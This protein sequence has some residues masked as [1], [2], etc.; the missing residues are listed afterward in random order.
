MNRLPKLLVITD[1]SLGEEPLLRQLEAALGAGP[2]VAV[3]HRNPGATARVYFEQGR[4]LK[5]LCDRFGA[6]LFVSARLDIA[7][8]LDAHLHLP[9]AALE[10]AQVRTR[11]P[12]GRWV[13]VAVHNEEE[14]ARAGGADLALVSPVF[15]TASKPG[16]VA[17]GAEGFARLARALPCPAYA[18]GG[19]T[20]GRLSGLA[21]VAG[22][23]AISAVLQAADPGAMSRA[24]C[25]AAQGSIGR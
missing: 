10:P 18:L 22:A 11:M 4:R 8:A 20:P 23:A 21:D 12:S 7:L 24:F 19:M 6:P 3:Q 13:C 9:A 5:A 2:F 16:A 25:A 17:L 1:W 15:V 14:A